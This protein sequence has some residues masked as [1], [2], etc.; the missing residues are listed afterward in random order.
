MASY[1]AERISVVNIQPRNIYPKVAKKKH[2]S[3]FNK[4]FAAGFCD[5]RNMRHCYCAICCGGLFVC[6]LMG[7]VGESKLSQCL[8]YPCAPLIL[9]P[10]IRTQYDIEGSIGMDILATSV[11]FP[12]SM[13]QLANELDHRSVS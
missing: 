8:T 1:Q 13:T 6:E 7:R 4:E 2:W 5:I 3:D 11:F 9:R 12:C 10:M